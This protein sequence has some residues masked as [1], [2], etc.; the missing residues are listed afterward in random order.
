MNGLQDTNMK[1][2]IIVPFFITA[3]WFENGVH[4]TYVTTIL[5]NKINLNCSINQF[6]KEINLIK[7]SRSITGKSQDIATYNDDH[8]SFKNIKDD[9]LTV[10]PCNGT[11]LQIQP[12]ELTDEGNYTCE[13]TASQGIFRNHFSLFVIAPPIISL[14]LNSLPN[15]V[16]KV[17]CTAA[18]SKPAAS[19]TW[20]ENTYGNTTQIL[21]NNVDG[22]VTVESHYHTPI[23]FTEK[24]Q[25]CI[26]NHPAFNAA[27]NLT[28]SLGPS[29]TSFGKWLQAVL[30]VCV[31]AL[32]VAGTIILVI[33]IVKKEM[34]KMAK[35]ERRKQTQDPED[36]IY[37]NVNRKSGKGGVVELPLN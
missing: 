25:T 35:S 5:G 15:G 31:S 23:N 27:Q 1:A 6:S 37:Q 7:W 19:I 22:T 20:K 28:I 14:N 16:K 33:W 17:Q 11:C 9:R 13:I 2:A 32:A 3:Y 34:K 36:P 24:Q 12:V 4:A 21:V 29:S 8:G 26:V 18:K 30:I 10:S